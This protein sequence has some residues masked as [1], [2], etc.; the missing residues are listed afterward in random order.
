MF[1]WIAKLLNLFSTYPEVFAAVVG[2]LVPISLAEVARA[3]YFPK[4]WTLRDQWKAILPFDFIS[5]YAITHT[6]WRFLD[7]DHDP[8]AL[9]FLGS[10]CFAVGTLAVHM[11]GVR[12]VLHK[13]PWL[14]DESG[15][16]HDS[17]HN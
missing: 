3:V 15:D 6:L 2:A 17:S 7:H 16:T 13:W 11:F 4:D 1:D 5:S 10:V 12:F 8:Q 14:G 9:L